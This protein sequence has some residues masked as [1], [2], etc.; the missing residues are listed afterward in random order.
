LVAPSPPNIPSGLEL[1]PVW[2]I[3]TALVHRDLHP[4]LYA[5]LKATLLPFLTNI[6]PG[7][8]LTALFFS[9]TILTESITKKKYPA[10]GM[11]QKR[12]GMFQPT[13]TLVKY[14]LFAPSEAESILWG[15]R[16]T[17]S[18]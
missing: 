1:P 7:L 15:N 18:D 12:V 8:S 17:K 10:Y 2:S 13:W 4:A 9:S 3:I 14:M 16:S 5:S 6:L 11:Y